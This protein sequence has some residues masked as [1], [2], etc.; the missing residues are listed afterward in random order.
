MGTGSNTS[1]IALLAVGGDKK[2]N[3][4]SEAVK[5]PKMTEL[6]RTSQQQL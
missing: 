4:G 2:G 3:L 6:A 1:T 5:Y